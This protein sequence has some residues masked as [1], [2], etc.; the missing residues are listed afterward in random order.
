MPYDD[1]DQNGQV[2]STGPA[3]DETTLTLWHYEPSQVA[4]VH[5]PEAV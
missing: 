4:W 2:D 1:A 5:V 3:L